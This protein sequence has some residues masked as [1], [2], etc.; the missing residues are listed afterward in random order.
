MRGRRSSLLLL[1]RASELGKDRLMWRT[2]PGLAA[3]SGYPVPVAVQVAAAAPQVAS[4]SAVAGTFTATAPSG[5]TAGNL[6]VAVCYDA[7]GSSETFTAPSG[8]SAP[9]SG[10]SNYVSG[11]VG[12]CV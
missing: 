2:L 1:I 11:A 9:S 8:W 10:A 5:V 6:L 7:Q 3:G 4:S 12:V